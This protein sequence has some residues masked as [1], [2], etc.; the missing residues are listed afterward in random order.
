MI[1]KR[2]LNL[3]KELFGAVV[4]DGSPSAEDVFESLKKELK[5]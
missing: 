2:Y 3:G 4:I 1:Q 5:V